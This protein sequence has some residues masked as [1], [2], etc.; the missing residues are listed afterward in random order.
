MTFKFTYPGLYLD[1]GLGWPFV[2]FTINNHAQC[3]L[4]LYAYHALAS[5]AFGG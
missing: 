1:E 4:A 2:T 5:A 3:E